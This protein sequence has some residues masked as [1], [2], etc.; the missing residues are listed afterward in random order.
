MF[1][2][3]VCNERFTIGHLRGRLRWQETVHHH[4]HMCTCIAPN[5]PLVTGHAHLPTC[6]SICNHWI[7]EG[8]NGSIINRN[9][10]KSVAAL[11]TSQS[12]KQEVA[13]FWIIMSAS[14]CERQS[15]N[16]C[17]HGEN[18]Q[19][20]HRKAPWKSWGFYPGSFL[21]QCESANHSRHL[22]WHIFNILWGIKCI[23]KLL[24]RLY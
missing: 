4:V 19:T 3:S 6:V 14:S 24:Y 9:S 5:S 17:R 11:T 7:D 16:L 1:V 20:P 23:F 22:Q 2:Y 8:A 21:L 15:K 13:N 10:S 18:M 12:S